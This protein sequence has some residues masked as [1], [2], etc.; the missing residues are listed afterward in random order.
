MH[1]SRPRGAALRT[2]DSVDASGPV[3]GKGPASEPAVRNGLGR[4]FFE[5]RQRKQVDTSWPEALDSVHRHLLG[6]ELAKTALEESERRYRSFFEGAPVG[7]FQMSPTGQLLAVNAAMA[8]ILGFD[9]AEQVLTEASKGELQ[10]FFK[11]NPW[12][13]QESSGEGHPLQSTVDLQVSCCNGRKKWVRLNIREVWAQGILIRLEGVAEDVTERRLAEI[14]TEVLAYYDLLTG[15]P[16]RTLFQERLKE[17]LISTRERNR[18]VALMLVEL[19]DFKVINDSLGEIFGDRLLQEVAARI[20]SGTSEDCP[21]ARVGGAEFAILLP[22]ALDIDQV[23]ATAKDMAAKLSAEYCFL[24]HSLSGQCNVGISISPDHGMESE[25]L[26]KRADMA[27]NRSRADGTR[28]TMFSEKLDRELME[29]MTLES[30]LRQALARNELF[31][32]YQPQVDMRTGAITGLEAL[33]RWNHSKLGLVSPNEFIGIAE[34]SGLIV[35]IGEW[36][37]RNACAQARA[38][39]AKGLPAVPVAVNVSA[40]QFRQRG[41]CDVVK[42]ILQETGLPPELL[43]LELTE[44][45]LLKNPEVMTSITALLRDMG[46][47]LAIDDFGTGYSSLGYL[48]SFK[49]NRLKIARSFVKDVSVDAD[50]AAITIAIIEMA[51]ALNLAVLAEGVELESQ[52]SFLRKQEC[53]TIQGFYFSRPASVEKVGRMLET[54]FSHMI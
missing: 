49:V 9:S 18:R 46:V 48:K 41:F 43:E 4:L 25:I 31:L 11:A 28:F 8:H 21:V 17:T 13:T 35:P 22:D 44:S 33:L 39:Q 27:L 1:A 16:N 5:R 54:G 7:M 14:R 32:E 34:N 50:D 42:N 45:L 38:W 30:G 40:I 10:G 29:R 24:G 47:T 15:L 26:M 2:E 3:T 36:V 6:L 20:R 23:K 12:E 19:E 53:Y 52:L 51:R 37:M